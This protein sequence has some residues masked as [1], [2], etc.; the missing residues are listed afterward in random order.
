MIIIYYHHHLPLT[1]LSPL[2]TNLFTGE[3]SVVV[4]SHMWL[5][6]AVEGMFLFYYLKIAIPIQQLFCPY[7]KSEA[8]K[9]Y[10]S[11]E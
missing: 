11:K 5:E 8:Q 6:W 1:L 2:L 3:E 9:W 7:G 4:E 10:H